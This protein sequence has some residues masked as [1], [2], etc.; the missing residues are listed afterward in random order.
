M[1]VSK[2]I[3]SVIL[4]TALDALVGAYLLVL[5]AALVN[6]PALLAPS[7]GAH[8]RSLRAGLSP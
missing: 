5:F 4:T 3:L 1:S 2:R 6:Y 7:H 8:G